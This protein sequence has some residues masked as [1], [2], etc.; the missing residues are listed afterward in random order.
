MKT[1]CQN[2]RFNKAQSAQRTA[3]KIILQQR[4]TVLLER[5]PSRFQPWL[6][7]L[8]RDVPNLFHFLHVLLMVETFDIFEVLREQAA[9]GGHEGVAM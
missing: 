2:K 8:H 5:G 1:I 4:D 6:G 7:R 3:F 9:R